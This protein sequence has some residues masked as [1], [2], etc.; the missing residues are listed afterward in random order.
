MKGLKK[1]FFIACVAVFALGIALSFIFNVP[2]GKSIATFFGAN[3]WE[4]LKIIPAAFVLIALFDVWVK[5][6]HVESRLGTTG[7]MKAHLWALLLAG[8]SVGGVYVAYPLARSLRKKGAS[9]TTIF[10][11]L[12][13]SSVCRI[14][15]LMFEMTFLGVK[16]TIVRL[17]VA[18][19][20]VILLGVL[21]GKYLQ[22]R[23][24]EMLEP[25]SDE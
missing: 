4:M 20:L 5:R 21:L 24:Y 22:K 18:I 25:N 23:D 12:G 6:E 3:L 10:V 9:L 15:M 11:Y 14:P 17:V 13:L 8:L 19:P 7:G 2:M 16:F 1:H